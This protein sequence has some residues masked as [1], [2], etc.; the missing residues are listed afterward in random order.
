MI[1]MTPEYIAAVMATIYRRRVREELL[2]AR[3][4]RGFG[5]WHTAGF[6]FHLALYWRVLAADWHRSARGR[7]S[8]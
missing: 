4:A 1:T 2:F 8:W 5:L 7:A 6:H 3:E